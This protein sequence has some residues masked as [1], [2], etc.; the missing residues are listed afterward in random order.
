MKK[1]LA[2][3]L[4]FA[5]SLTG[6]TVSAQAVANDKDCGDFSDNQAVMNFWYSNGYSAT[7]DPHDL[8]R[9]NDGLPCEVSKSD[10]NSFVAS[11]TDDTDKLD[12]STSDEATQEEST[13]NSS[14]TEEQQTT[15]ENSNS[16]KASTEQKEDSKQQGE[17]LPKTATNSVTMMVVAFGLVAAGL[18][19]VFRRKNVKA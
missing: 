3:I 12:K 17:E 8:D 19:L 1:V 2:A 10:Y 15:T 5:F 7:N 16:E 9:D 6:Y 14:T 4:I 11:K 18:L 13:S